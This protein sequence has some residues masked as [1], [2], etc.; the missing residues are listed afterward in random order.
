MQPKINF[1]D[2]FNTEQH[3]NAHMNLNDVCPKCGQ[4]SMKM[5]GKKEGHHCKNVF[6]GYRPMG[7]NSSRRR[8]N[9]T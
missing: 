8:W 7:R 2:N 1:N 9:I 5:E 6:C 3:S 4:H